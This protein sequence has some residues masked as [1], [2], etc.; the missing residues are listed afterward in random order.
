MNFWERVD[1][2]I[3]ANNLTRKQLAA[4]AGFDVSN[5]NKGI[6][7]NNSPSATT[8]VKIAEILHTTVEY[9]V[10]GKNPA[11]STSDT[12]ELD[13]LYKYKRTIINLDSLPENSRKRIEDLISEVGADYKAGSQN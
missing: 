7:D 6:K 8:A 10:T 9:L 13:T 4:E 2:L 1:N 11:L 5:I 3:E 12:Q